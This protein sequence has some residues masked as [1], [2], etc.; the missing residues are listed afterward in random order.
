MGWEEEEGGGGR[1]RGGMGRRGGRGR[2]G[3]GWE[4][5]EGEEAERKRGMG[6]RRGR[7]R[8]RGGGGWEGEE[9]GGGGILFPHQERPS[10]QVSWESCDHSCS[11]L[12]GPASRNYASHSRFMNHRVPAHKRYQPT[13]YEHA[14]N[15]ATHAVSWFLGGREG[16]TS[17]WEGR[18]A[19]YPWRDSTFI[20]RP[21]P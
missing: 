3:V 11:Q 5:E 14:A 20:P 21:C 10:L 1:G 13:E 16:D 15:C 19:L 18:Q 6:R 8:G 2:G 7:G 12:P 17:R 9:E 4:G